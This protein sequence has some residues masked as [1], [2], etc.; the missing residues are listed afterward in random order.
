VKLRV[1]VPTLLVDGRDNFVT[2][3]VTKCG[4]IENLTID[5]FLQLLGLSGVRLGR[6]LQQH[7]MLRE[8]S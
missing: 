7:G 8:I 4:E 3:K 6:R 1:G 5:D 2:S